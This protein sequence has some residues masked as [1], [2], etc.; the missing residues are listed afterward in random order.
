MPKHRVN[1]DGT[2]RLHSKISVDDNVIGS[3]KLYLLTLIQ[4]HGSLN[5]AAKA[6][7]INYR[8]AWMLLETLQK[9]FDQP[10]VISERGGAAQG[11][12]TLT[13]LGQE[14]IDRY[15]THTAALDRAAQPFLD[16]VV[17]N[18]STDSKSSDAKQTHPSGK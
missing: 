10:L 6:M 11:G 7:N 13:T 2:P 9:C 18:K 15:T 14:L 5:A 1:P 16:W 4:E 17:D 8:R 3:G 12:T